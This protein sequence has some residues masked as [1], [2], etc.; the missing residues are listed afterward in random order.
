MTEVERQAKLGNRRQRGSP[1]A[2]AI[3]QMYTPEEVCAL[4]KI[5]RSRLYELLDAGVISPTY[6]LG[7]RAR[8]IPAGAI[9]RYLEGR[10]I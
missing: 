4:L 3:D 10:T 7:H 8:R 9:A 2:T 6:K 1:R 5:G